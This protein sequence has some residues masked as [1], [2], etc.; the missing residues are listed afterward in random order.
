[1]AD[2]SRA[3]S[4]RAT[5]AWSTPSVATSLDRHD[6]GA[7]CAVY[8]DGRLVVDLWGGIADA[9][10]RRPWRR[11]TAAVIF[12]C[13]KGL[14]AVCAYLLVQERRLDL[15]APIVTLL[16]RVRVR[17]QVGDHRPRRDEPSRRAWPALDVDL[18]FEDVLDWAIRSIRAIE[19]QPPRNPPAMGH[20]YH[21]QTYGWLVGEI[22]RRITGLTPG[23]YFRLA[24]GRSTRAPDL[25]RTAG[26]RATVGRLDGGAAARRGLRSGARLPPG[27]RRR[28]HTSTAARRWAGR[29]H[30]PPR[31]GFVTFNDP[32]FQAAEIPGRQRHQHGGVT[33][34][35]VRSLRLRRRWDPPLLSAASLEDA[36][37][38]R[39]EGPQLSGHA[40]R[41][42]AVGYRLPAG[43]AARAADA[44]ADQLRPCRRRWPARVRRTSSTGSASPSWATRWAATATAGRAS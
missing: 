7:A 11:D 31:D 2:R 26:R 44:R 15:D 3:S 9:G 10:T 16:A 33:R 39:A 17:R 23:R 43:V 4:T 5:A 42:G 1:M 28:I 18:R 13:S 14:L 27:S 35:P 36:L 29:L 19:A 8:V 34:P 24:V 40:G 30:S 32:A 22:I 41:R 12:S 21:P 25:D 37:R 38:V 20:D 6:L